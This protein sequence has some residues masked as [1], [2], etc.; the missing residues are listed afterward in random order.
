[1]AFAAATCPTCHKR[2]QV[3]LDTDES[4]CMYCGGLVSGAA[5]ASSAGSPSLDNLMGMARTAQAAGNQIEAESYFNRV[6][7]LDPS[8]SEAWMGKGKSAGW[9]STL[10]NMRFGEMVAS[11]S[12]AIATT[13]DADKEET[14]KTCLFEIN[15]LIVTLYGMS[16]KHMLEF[17]AIPA[18][19][20]DYISNVSAML[21]TLETASSWMPHDRTTL[22][23]IVHLCKDNIEGVAFRDEFD[24]NT[25]K[26]W[27]LSDEYE[28]LMRHKMETAAAAIREIDPDYITPT[29]EAKKPDACFVVTATMGDT[30]H[31]T[32]VLMRQFRDQ[33]I[34]KRR[35][36]P[37]FVSWY[38]RYGPMAASF[39]S[40][41]RNRRRASYAILVYPLSLI[42]RLLMRIT[43]KP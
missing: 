2:I 11:F 38:Y 37:G 24:N 39:I 8:I 13:E 3:P 1:M 27:K 7:E 33:W 26:S 32:V 25:S 18:S 6:L 31:P 20:S 10:M 4:R 42:A 15:H 12:H 16:R 17:V 34:L 29:A 9:Q 22:D 35:G 5:R 41:S 30:S 21:T 40:A 36:G 19:W 28:S 14:I 23:N 43:P